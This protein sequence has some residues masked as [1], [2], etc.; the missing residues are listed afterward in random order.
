[1]LDIKAVRNTPDLIKRG[2]AERGIQGVNVDELLAL[3]QLARNLQLQYDNARSAQRKATPEEGRVLKAEMNEADQKLGEVRQKLKELMLRV[4]N[5]MAEDTPGGLDDNANL[6]LAVYGKKP[7][8][9]F[10]PKDHVEI[11]EKYGLDI[12]AGTNVSG[13]G[14]PILRGAVALLER[15]LMQFT[16]DE[17]M[18]RGF[19]YMQVPVLA[20]LEILR[21]IGFSP[22]RDDAQTEI[23]NLADD[24]LCLTGT[25]EIALVGHL[26]DKTLDTSSLPIK[27]V[28]QTPCFRR[29]GGASGRRDRGLYRQKMFNKTELVAITMPDKADAML[30]EIRQFEVDIFNKLGICF[31]VVRVCAGDMGLP[32]YKKYDLE[33]LMYG[34]TAEGGWGWGELTSCSNCTDFQSRR[35]NIYYKEGNA[36]GRGELVYTLNG[37]GITTRALIPLLEQFQQED[38]SVRI[39]EVLQPYM[40]GRK[41]L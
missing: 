18:K 13:R 2:I 33:G 26:A 4:P 32:A 19:E 36:K 28:G 25:A 27:L 3:D 30:E 35:L 8:F 16:L 12:D 1:M 29:E 24:D 9:S 39:P 37:T 21:G 34:R 10:T 20:R 14:F 38:G 11:G 7:E 31:R 6:E 23:F 17:A 22:R 15:A 41:L 40:G 5:F